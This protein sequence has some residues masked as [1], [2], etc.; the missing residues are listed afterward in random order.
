MSNKIPKFAIAALFLFL[1]LSTSYAVE[2]GFGTARKVEG[3]HFTAYFA[4]PLEEAALSRKLN[5]SAAEG[6][7]IGGATAVG[8]SHS[9]DLGL[10]NMLDTLFLQVSDILDMHIYS[11]TGFIKVCRDNSQLKEIYSNLFNSELNHASFYVAEL[12]TIYISSE[13]FT[14]EILG[15]E[16]AHALIS[17]YFVVQPPVKIQEVLAGYVEYQLRRAQ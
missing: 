3:E 7:I 11:Y 9:S 15:H 13:S 5:I 1:S 6:I 2:D 4:S 10:A 17:R 12:N 14:K 16:I 8:G